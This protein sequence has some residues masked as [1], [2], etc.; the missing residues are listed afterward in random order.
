MELLEQFVFPNLQF[1]L[2]EPLRLFCRFLQHVADSQELRFVVFYHAAVRRDIDF[3][4]SEGIERINRFV[5]RDARCEVYLYL[6]AGGGEVLHLACLDFTF[7][8]G[9]GDALYQ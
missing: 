2:E 9:F 3:A 4:V 6:D 8:Y 7:L 5:A 1:A